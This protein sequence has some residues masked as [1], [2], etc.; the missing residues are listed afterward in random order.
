[1]A[2]VEQSVQMATVSNEV[3][4]AYA[5]CWDY[6]PEGAFDAPKWDAVGKRRNLEFLASRWLSR[7]DAKWVLQQWVKG[8][9]LFHPDLLDHLPAKAQVRIAREGS[10]ALYVARP[11]GSKMRLPSAAKMAAD[12]KHDDIDLLGTRCVRYWWD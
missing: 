6:H 2:T 10:V 7:D 11:F 5:D 4:E 1:M 3:A 12:E 9:N 8:Y